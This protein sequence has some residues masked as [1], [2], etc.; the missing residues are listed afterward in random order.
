RGA[1]LERMAREQYTRRITLSARRGMILDRHG[2]ELAVEVEVDSVYVDQRK[3]EDPSRTAGLLAA[4]LELDQATLTRKLDGDRHFVWLKRRVSPKA[5]EQ[6]RA[7]AISGV[8]LLKESKRFYP[9]RTLAA[10]LIGYAGIDSKG[11]EGVE[12]K[13]DEQLMGNRDAAMG[14]RD[15][16]GRVIFA[17][18]FFGADGVVG[19]SVELTI[20]RTIQYIV[21]QELAKTVR[22]YEARAGQVVVMDP[23]SG[24]ILALASWPTFN[25]NTI[26]SSDDEQR[27]NRPVLDVFEPGSTFK[28]FTL[29]AVLDSGA[30]R[31]D[32]LTFCEQGR[33]EMWDVTIHDDHRDGWLNTT[34][35]LKRSSNICFAKMAQKLGKRRFYHYLRR[36]G[37]G[38][39]T[40]VSLPFEARGSLA[41]YSKWFD[42]DTATVAFGQGVG[43]TGLQFATALSAVANGGTLME[44][45]LVRR[46]VGA[47]GETIGSFSPQARRR[48]ISRY[49]ARLVTDMM[50]AVTEEGG[51]GVQAAL[52]GY[53]V[54]GKTGTAQK[55]MGSKGYEDGK[56]VTSFVGFVP[57]DKPRLA[58][59]IVIDEP[60]INHY[61]GTVAAPAFQRIADKTLR[62]LGVPPQIPQARAT[63]GRRALPP[64]VAGKAVLEAEPDGQSGDPA[65]LAKG[66]VRVPELLGMTM[67]R[68]LS[69]LDGAGL[70]PV[71]M[72]SG[73]AVE[74]IPPAGEPLAAG[75]FVQ[76]NFQPLVEE[77]RQ[78]GSD[79]NGG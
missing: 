8:D 7:L 74:Q 52:D 10:Q 23:G 68:A 43:T 3:I 35:C 53:L 76:V 64:P 49:T 37:F 60:R 33:M 22:T 19:G 4:A 21:E 17:E 28:I 6:V 40:H 42:V 36:F 39:Q 18:G 24:E 50:T 15:A 79:G 12:R 32:E 11:L 13:F 48:V 31:A 67:P 66:E 65:A 78:D 77:A 44:P 72:G 58:I 61:G 57:S 75:A 30:V 73:I 5:A 20:D 9:G 69:A 14:L 16:S 51:T 1:E 38:E 56:W 2:E 45:Q 29:A 46:I 70:R 62:Y 25:P 26:G 34:Q 63:A 27:R 71:L 41:H 55:S 59:S 47:D 54:A